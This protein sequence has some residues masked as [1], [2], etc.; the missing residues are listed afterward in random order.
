MNH[1]HPWCQTRETSGVNN[2]YI[3]SNHSSSIDHNTLMYSSS[4]HSNNVDH[5]YRLI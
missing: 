3:S 5:H 2:I 4:S 1:H